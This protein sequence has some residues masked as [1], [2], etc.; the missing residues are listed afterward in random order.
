MKQETFIKLKS[1]VCMI[2]PSA[3]FLILLGCYPE[4]P[5][6]VEEYDVVYTNYQ[7]DFNF[8]NT[9]TYSLP[10][11]VL[12][13]DDRAPEDDPEFVDPLFGDAILSTIR[14]NLNDKGWQEVEDNADVV[15]LPSAFD[16]DFV[17]FYD[18][19]YWCWY[20][21]CWGWWYPGYSPGYV[22]GYTTGTVL[23]QMTYP[24]GVQDNDVPV[25][26]LGAMNGLLQGSDANL[27]NRINTNIN[28]AFSQPPFD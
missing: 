10:D 27:V 13:L 26:W 28:Q 15:I 23:I 18:P 14:Q 2:L 7:S 9:Y 25:I 20:Y 5:E 3:L 17:Y 1:R 21:P 22:S 16:T 19:G 8:S 24:S 6:F 11:G 4:Q 12:L